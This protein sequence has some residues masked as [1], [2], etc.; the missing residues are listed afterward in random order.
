MSRIFHIDGEI[1]SVNPYA[2]NPAPAPVNAAGF[3][4]STADTYGIQRTVS[5]INGLR[6]PVTV[7][8]R[9][10]VKYT[11]PPLSYMIRKRFTIKE[12][13]V[14][15][16]SIMKDL[17]KQ[18]TSVNHDM[19]S[20]DMK[21]I[22]EEYYR[23]RDVMCFTTF[24][25][26]IYT[27]IKEDK[28]N[29]YRNV[30][31]KD[32]DVF[33]SSEN[34]DSAENHPFSDRELHGERYLSMIQGNENALQFI[35]EIID[36]NDNIGNRYINF[37]KEIHRIRPTKDPNRE[38]GVYLLV[39]DNTPDRS[40]KNVKRVP[41]DK[42]DELYGLYKNMDDAR[43]GGDS[44][45]IY[46]KEIETLKYESEKL[47]TRNKILE[48]EMN[49]RSLHRKDSS[50]SLKYMYTLILTTLGIMLALHKSK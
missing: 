6:Y 15:P 10:G 39:T 30:Y 11:I 17:E 41:I 40:I 21:I 1:S 46:S 42:A 14:I 12:T 13:Y 20:K 7:C 49:D 23:I 9:N 44:K 5:Y 50:E 18:Y 33:I 4:P 34:I 35:I 2:Y 48:E 47:K 16:L 3:D 26:D 32:K 22:M 27:D 25:V 8:E 19:L 45:L 36:N 37:A 38:D 29:D 31:V 28:L 24:K 43:S